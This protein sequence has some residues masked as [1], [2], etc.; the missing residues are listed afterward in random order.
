MTKKK[1][2]RTQVYGPRLP[3]A[4]TKKAIK[5]KA[6]KR[7]EL[8]RKAELA[9]ELKMGEAVR[10][11]ENF[12]EKPTIGS[13]VDL[14]I[15]S[16]DDVSFVGQQAVLGPVD[17]RVGASIQP[18]DLPIQVMP[19]FEPPP[20]VVKALQPKVLSKKQFKSQQVVEAGRGWR[21]LNCLR[22][23]HNRL[24]SCPYCN[25]RRRHS[26]SVAK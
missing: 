2:K 4:P 17:P 14:A 21:C 26:F 25:N 16:Y 20:D 11:V 12:M 15:A 3:G 7:K 1:P 5:E 6:R 9:R 23:L 19:A 8:P 18:V 24:R 22:V 10:L 13:P